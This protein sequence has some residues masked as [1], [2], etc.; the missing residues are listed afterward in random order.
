MLYDEKGMKKR[1][2]ALL[3]NTSNLMPSSSSTF[4]GLPAQA[5][6]GLSNHLGAV[7]GGFLCAHVYRALCGSR[8]PMDSEGKL[9]FHRHIRLPVLVSVVN[10]VSVEH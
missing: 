5:I 7:H 3:T 9:L 6:I 10:L 8:G 2:F 4:A 1:D